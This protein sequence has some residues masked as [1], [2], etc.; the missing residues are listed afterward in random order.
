M[1]VLALLGNPNRVFDQQSHSSGVLNPDR[2]SRVGSKNIWPWRE[3]LL[4]SS[5]LGRACHIRFQLKSAHRDSPQGT[6]ALIKA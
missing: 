6:S 3:R 1:Y 2:S 5:S 4:L